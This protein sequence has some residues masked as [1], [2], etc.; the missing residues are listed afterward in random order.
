MFK[1][2]DAWTTPSVT[3]AEKIA[4]EED[5]SAGGKSV[6]T[7]NSTRAPNR[8]VRRVKAALPLALSIRNASLKGS[9]AIDASKMTDLSWLREEQAEDPSEESQG[10][11][12]FLRSELPY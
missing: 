3:F 6:P 8:I 1:F 7:S 9:R 4:G 2:T 5:P 11:G 10:R 12:Y